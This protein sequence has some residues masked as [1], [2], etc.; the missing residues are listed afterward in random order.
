VICKYPREKQALMKTKKTFTYALA[1][2][3]FLTGCAGVEKNIVAVSDRINQEVVSPNKDLRLI[4]TL[5]GKLDE[6]V[7]ATAKLKTYSDD[8]IACLYKALVD[9]AFYFHE[10]DRY[11]KLQRRVLAEKVRRNKYDRWDLIDMCKSY[12]LVREFSEAAILQKQLSDIELITVPEVTIAPSVAQAVHW[13][14]YD[15]SDKGLK[16]ELK[17]LPL[18]HGPAVIMVIQPGCVFAEAAMGQIADDKELLPVFTK[19]G[20]IVTEQ[21]DGSGIVK[22]KEDFKFK[23]VYIIE[24]EK[25]FPGLAFDA[26]PHFYFL[27]DGKIVDQFMG[28]DSENPENGIGKLR[29]AME[30]IIDMS[31]A[32]I[33]SQNTNNPAGADVAS[34]SPVI[35]YSTATL[36]KDTTTSVVQQDDSP[37]LMKDLLS[38]VPQKDRSEFLSKLLI[39]DGRV[40]STDNASLSK[41]LNDVE[42]DKVLKVLYTESSWHGANKS[43]QLVQ[44][45]EVL[46]NVPEAV[47]NEFMDNIMYWHGRIVSVYV[48]NLRKVMGERKARKILEKLLPVAGDKSACSGSI[49]LDTFCGPEKTIDGA[50]VYSAIPKSGWAS[51]PACNQSSLGTN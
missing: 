43:H 49:C 35:R 39:N 4:A 48:D 40:L 44:P 13:R 45:S 11:V 41:T 19:Y 29:K 36:S 20:T 26:S 33:V 46:K 34:V 25:S 32:E 27:K 28:W 50:I 23:N 24:N 10:D 22:F 3:M 5:S 1:T 6:S 37:V 17:A 7:L 16:A 21:F 9:S 18:E 30:S 51:S 42:I 12:M 47:R 2:F 8:T 14:V 38:T 15:V 31:H